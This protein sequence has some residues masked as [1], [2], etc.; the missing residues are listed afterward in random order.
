MGV[1]DRDYYRNDY[2]RPV[3]VASWSAV[4]TLIVINV[5]IF[6]ADQFS[7]DLGHGFRWLDWH[8]ALWSNVYRHPSELWQFVTYGFSHDPMSIMHILGNMF[9]LWLFGRDV[10]AI[11]GKV[12]FYKLY[13]SLIVLAG[14]AWVVIQRI[15]AP[16]DVV[17]TIGASGAVMGIMMVYIFH[18]P[19]RTFL[20]MFAIPMPAWVLGILYVYFDLSGAL[21][22]FRLTD[23][24]VNNVAHLAGAAFGILFYQTHWTLFS[25]WPE[26]WFKS[27]KR[28]RSGYR[29]YR[30]DR[31]RDGDG[32]DPRQ[33][34]KRVDDILAKISREGEASLTAEERRTLEEASRKYRG[35]K[36]GARS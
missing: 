35:D 23:Q 30:G 16:G 25:L 8:M 2:R 19:H 9:A 36:P 24:S 13:F 31:D 6:I 10:E 22:G 20:F 3:G 18:F 4:T 14:F 15:V 5:A 34:Q 28:R 29:V 1:Y 33:L 26:S 21:G 7:P 32:G 12:Q 17:P 11:Y 27:V